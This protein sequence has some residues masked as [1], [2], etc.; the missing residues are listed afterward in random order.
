MSLNIEGAKEE[1]KREVVRGARGKGGER[2]EDQIGRKTNRRKREGKKEKEKEEFFATGR[3]SSVVEQPIAARQVIRSNRIASYV[4]VPL[5]PL[6]A[7]L[8]A[9]SA[10]RRL[11]K[12]KGNLRDRSHVRPEDRVGG[13]KPECRRAAAS[14]GLRFR[15]CVAPCNQA[16]MHAQPAHARPCACGDC[17]CFLSFPTGPKSVGEKSHLLVTLR[18]S[19]AEVSRSKRASGYRCMP[20]LLSCACHSIGR[21][22]SAAAQ[23]QQREPV[24]KA[25]RTRTRTRT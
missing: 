10:A 19:L 15:T 20:L 6:L 17:R 12:H 4:P 22:S 16:A 24:L 18:V 2:G 5:P 8:F 25:C 9:R 3:F 1:R 14:A 21:S 7:I 11:Q 23:Q 13:K